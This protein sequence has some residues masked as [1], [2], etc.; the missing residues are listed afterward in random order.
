MKNISV[1]LDRA[2]LDGIPAATLPDGF[3]FRGYEPGDREAWVQLYAAAER[4]VSITPELFDSE[5]KRNEV[6][7]SRRML[8][9]LDGDD[10]PVG[11]STGW[12]DD[13][14]DRAIPGRVHW[15]AIHPHYQGR[16][17]AKPLL[18]RTLQLLRDLGHPN[19]YL[20]TSTGRTPAI[21][22]YLRY[23]FVPTIETV[24]QREGWAEALPVLPADCQPGVARA[25][26]AARRIG[27]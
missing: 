7:L 17:L 13:F 18:S 8:F 3:R 2:S 9:L 5:F 16:K 20:M 12:A 27:L 10:R 14:A 26:Q 24:E 22:L 23:G 21:T 11:T 6:E 25:L 1:R 15:V 19:A 4:F